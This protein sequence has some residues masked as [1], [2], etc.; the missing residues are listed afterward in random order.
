MCLIY[1]LVTLQTN[2]N[3]LLT[4]YEANTVYKSKTNTDYK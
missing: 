1:F 3:N 4:L 2:F